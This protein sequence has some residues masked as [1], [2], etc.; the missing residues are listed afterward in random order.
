MKIGKVLELI[1]RVVWF[2]FVGLS[3][4]AS[5]FFTVLWADRVPLP[6]GL[7]IRGSLACIGFLTGALVFTGL[8][9]LQE[10]LRKMYTK[11]EESNVPGTTQ[12]A[13]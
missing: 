4:A 10:K 9:A 5:C 7:E 11:K 1:A 8:N 6:P 2:T 12:L 3:T 13:P